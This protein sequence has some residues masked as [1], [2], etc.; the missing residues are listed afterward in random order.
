MKRTIFAAA[1]L[2]LSAAVT[3]GQQLCPCVPLSHEWVV[4]ACDTWN[5]ASSAAI[6]ANGDPNVLTMPAATGD[7]RWLVIKR[8]TS[9][10]YVAPADAPFVVESFDGA[11]GATAR[12][13]AMPDHAPLLLSAPDGKFLVVMLKDLAPRRR[14]VKP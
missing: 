2:M 14:A 3:S 9:G 5:C 11:A 1:M 12:F 4:E 8:V 6:L 10:S 7:G 13:A